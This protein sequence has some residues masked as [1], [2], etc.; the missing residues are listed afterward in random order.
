MKREENGELMNYP[1]VCVIDMF[2]FLLYMLELNCCWGVDV[3]RSLGE[4]LCRIIG[5][6]GKIFWVL[7]GNRRILGSLLNTDR[8]VMKADRTADR[9]DSTAI[10]RLSDR[11][12]GSTDRSVDRSGDRSV[13]AAC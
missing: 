13:I 9:S 1:K 7:C 3:M 12:V 4:K 2:K 10:E 6:F 5:V 11:S 8:S